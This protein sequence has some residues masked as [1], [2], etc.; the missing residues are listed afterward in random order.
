MKGKQKL[1]V[2]G[3]KCTLLVLLL[4]FNLSLFTCFSQ[5]NL[6]R[7]SSIAVTIAGTT[8]KF[9]WAG[10][11][12]FTN[13][14]LID[15]NN[16]G[17]ND[18]VVY[19]KSGSK[20]RTF[21]N[22]KVSGQANYTHNPV[23]EDKFPFLNSWFST[24][25]YN[26]D[27]RMDIFTYSLNCGGIK[28]FRNTGNLQFVPMGYY[29]SSCGNTYL[30]SDYGT[31]ATPLP[32]IPDNG[33]GM[34]GL[35][36]MDGDGD[37]DIIVFD[38]LAYNVEYHQNQSKE[39]YGN[40]DSLTFTMVNKC[41]GGFNEGMCQV[42]LNQ[43]NCPT[44]KE[45]PHDTLTQSMHAGS[46]LMCFDADGDS[47]IDL[48]EGDLSCD[49]VFFMSNK[50]TKAI[51]HMVSYTTTYPPSKPIDMNIFPTGYFLDVNNDNKRD[52]VAAPNWQGSINLN[53]QW[54]YINGG[55]DNSP[56][57]NYIKNNF[58]QGDMIDV[59][60]GAYPTMFDYDADGD[61]DLL[62]GN[63]GYHS[64][65]GD[66]SAV[67]LYQN[68]GT[69]TAPSFSL[70]TTNFA[71]LSSLHIP[72]MAPTTGDLDGDGD[73]DLLIG[74]NNGEFYYFENTAGPGNTA[75]FSSTPTA[76][77]GLA[78]SFLYN[79]RAGTNK[80]YPQLI[81]L[82]LDGKLDLISGA[83]NGKVFYFRNTGTSTAPT[84]SLITN[85]LGNINVLQGTCSSLGNSMPF[86][87]S[88]AGAYKMIVGSECGNMFLYDVPSP[89]NLGNA[90][91]LVNSNAYGI[92]GGEHTAP[93]FFD[94]NGDT[95]LDLMLGNYSGGL[96]FYHGLSST[97]YDIKENKSSSNWLVFPNPAAD[98]VHVKFNAVNVATKKLQLMDLSGRII[99]ETSCRDNQ[100][101]INVAELAN[102]IYF[103]NVQVYSAGNN[104]ESTFTQKIIVSHE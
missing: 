45:N 99:K 87:F 41:W 16:D 67:A 11:L 88:Y 14:G 13:W 35:V 55:A 85:A 40:C 1:K 26:C 65:A 53:N 28:V 86:V 76:D 15:L 3:K 103:L 71:N 51:A 90:F 69:A 6:Q 73:A 75:V 93:V 36:D 12:N 66:T 79:I 101:E 33:V 100:T 47:L 4:T 80:S 19:D 59:G 54:L 46:G 63:F 98:V 61:L 104:V 50:G 91:T 18:L 56:N 34:P 21:I 22:D 20:I 31:G 37:M 30:Q 92:Y 49:S 58:L 32:N 68:T 24:Y 8:L 62:L 29:N 78:G 70:I 23:Y 95:H 7:D 2:K 94:L 52:L 81:D 42:T 17:F 39:L 43:S 97:Y 44:H 5:P 57:F 9:P 10:G 82:D 27:G 96:N 25:D 89:A 83:G 102:G 74:V 72:N 48:L 84:F 60:E 77:Y 64:P 38:V